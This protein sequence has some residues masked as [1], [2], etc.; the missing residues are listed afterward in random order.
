[1][2]GNDHP[3]GC[4][5]IAGVTHLLRDDNLESRGYVRTAEFYRRGAMDAEE[6]LPNLNLC[7]HRVSAVKEPPELG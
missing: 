2:F 1:M 4:G 3:G 6:E 5:G 7:V